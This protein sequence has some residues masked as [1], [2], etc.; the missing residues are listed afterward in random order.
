MWTIIIHPKSIPIVIALPGVTTATGHSCGPI[1]DT[2]QP[3]TW[4]ESF[5]NIQCYDS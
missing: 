3:E 5:L 2:T 4:T 1:R